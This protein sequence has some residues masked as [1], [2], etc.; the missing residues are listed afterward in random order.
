[1]VERAP[2]CG[3][4]GVR[5]EAQVAEPARD[6]LGTGER[7]SRSML[8]GMTRIAFVG[9]G[10]M[11][12]PM[13][14]NLLAAGHELV[15]CDVDPAGAASLGIP[16]VP[17]PAR[18]A[19]DAEVAIMSLPS[20]AAVEE[21]AVGSSGLLAGVSR[22]AVVI[23]M[24]TSP[25]SLARRLAAAFEDAGVDFLDAPVSGGPAGAE[26]A[27]LAIMVG[28]RREAFERARPV[29]EAMGSLIE[30]VGDT[31]AG[32]AV[33]LCNNLIVGVTMA[34]MSEACDLLERERIDPA[35]AFEV[36]TRS[37]GDS[38]V[39]RRRFPLP[40][41]RPEHPAS[42][43]YEPLFRLDLLRK[44]LALALEFAAEH[45]IEAP[46]TEIAARAY[47]A[48]LEAGLGGLDY[49]AVYRARRP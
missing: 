49:S 19:R 7:G 11:G 14:A 37:T 33:K 45:G 5:V 23:D 29:L 40:G 24:S 38:S 28:G 44:D 26:A 47:D 39:L 3:A 2:D 41:V 12:R 35:Q 46:V 9:V 13:A 8:A 27:T 15:A 10:T 21:V 36:F 22:D 25:P 43:G 1:M 18:A 32:Q 42:N 20:P 31:G 17:T 30:L 34:A 16:L 6:C 4:V 48:A